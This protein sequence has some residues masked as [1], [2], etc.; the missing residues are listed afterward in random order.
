MGNALHA[1]CFAAKL[2]MTD[3]KL[4]HRINKKAKERFGSVKL[5]RKAAAKAADAAGFTMADWSRP[6]TLH[7]GNWGVQILLNA[8]PDVFLLTEPSRDTGNQRLWTITENGLALADKALTEAVI[9][10]PVY[11]PRV[12]RPVEWAGFYARVAEDDR[13]VASAPL[14]RTGHKDI[15]A[16]AR[17]AMKSG[18]MT[19][20]VTALNVLQEVPFK[21]NTWIMEVITQCY[22]HG[23]RVDGLPYHSPIEVPKRLSLDAFKALSVEER[24]LISKTIRGRK[25]ANRTRV[26]DVI[27]FTEDMKIAKRL[28]EAERYHTP[29]NLDWRSRVYSLAHFNFQREDRVRAMFLFANG[30]PIGEEGLY[31][32]KVHVA[33][34]GAFDKVDKQSMEDR[35]AWVDANMEMITDYVVNPVAN[36]GWTQADSPF[37]FLAA[38]HDLWAAINQGPGYVSHFPVS[39]DGSCSG[40][41]HLA[42]MTLAPEGSLVNLTNN[43]TPA[44]VYQTV[45]NIVKKMI[46]ADLD[47]NELFG[48]VD[49]EHKERKTI[50]PISKLARTALAY[51]VDRKLVKRNVMTFAY[52]SKE[53]G[54]SEQHYED[55]MEP[56]ELKLLKGEVDKHPFGETEDEWR[57]CSRYFAK[58]ILAAIKEVVRLPAEAMSFMQTLAKALA[59]EG[60]PLRWVSPAGV[61]CINRYHERTS[62]RVSLWLDDKG[63]KSEIRMWVATGYEAPIAKDK[64]ASGIA[65]NFVHSHDAAHLLL[66]VVASANEGIR[67]IATVHDS[68]GCL[69]SRATR[70]NAIIR[71][72]F[73][74]MYTERDVLAD[75]LASARADL[76]PANHEKLPEL[77]EKGTLDLKEIINARYAFA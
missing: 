53:F 25:K 52:S 14:L 29:M 17:H 59:H 8:M 6:M 70:F 47:S 74:R 44:D 18:Q 37:L 23:V 75:L 67:D 48:K 60:K 73:L 36:Q 15:I 20:A 65:P 3:R 32:L 33:N 56:L 22:E 21:I 71:E 30:E 77:P 4:A 45:A 41:Q 68:F 1:E 51:G 72:T 34:C 11:Q 54:M 64:A 76:T 66:T 61:P 13:T 39:F 50:A 46:E 16:A 12:E 9:T 35:V 42:A 49:E 31:W 55:T 63:V 5:R 10:S 28:A 24:K 58:R 40:L 69:P 43:D 19:P 2:L 57:L 26:A 62:E 27:Q 7:A 38:A